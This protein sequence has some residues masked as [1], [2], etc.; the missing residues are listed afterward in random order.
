MTP[1]GRSIVNAADAT[2]TPEGFGVLYRGHYSRMVSLAYL[3]TGST[4]A[5]EDIVQDVFVKV[6]RRWGKI[7]KP[8]GYLRAAVVNACRSH[9]RRTMVERRHPP[10]PHKSQAAPSEPDEMWQRLTRLSPRRRAA[11]VLRF[12]EDLSVA[13]VA[14]VLGCRQQTAKS[15]IHRG[16]TQLR[17]ELT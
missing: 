10:A 14:Q 11:L 6:Y 13:Q 15:L 17:G 5:A 1:T 9:H 8:A 3:L 4:A 12:Y 7:D 2:V 16:L